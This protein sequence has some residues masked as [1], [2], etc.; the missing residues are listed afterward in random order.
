MPSIKFGGPVGAV[1]DASTGATVNPRC[2][3]TATITS[4]E[5]EPRAKAAI[6][7]AVADQLARSSS[8]ATAAASLDQAAIAAAAAAEL[9]A[10]ITIE[11][12][13]VKL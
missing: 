11:M 7:R 9:G 10:P 3:G 6:M 4:A 13:S 1:R 12:L 2:F 8:V 5:L